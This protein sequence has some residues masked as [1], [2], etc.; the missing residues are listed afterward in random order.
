MNAP[1]P[2]Q[3]RPTSDTLPQFATPD[4]RVRL[5]SMPVFLRHWRRRLKAWVHTAA[6]VASCLMKNFQRTSVSRP[7]ENRV[8]LW[9]SVYLLKAMRRQWVTL[10]S[11]SVSAFSGWVLCRACD[12]LQ[13]NLSVMF[14]V[15]KFYSLELTST[16][17][18][19]L[20]RP[21]DS[22]KKSQPTYQQK[23]TRFRIAATWSMQ[24]MCYGHKS[25]IENA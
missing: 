21:C 23:L 19:I 22:G 2:L 15:W 9:T 4:W 5:V 1:A 16:A 14:Y 11:P 3:P 6:M 10:A 8:A 18:T 24:N 12:S 20:L 7:L 13:H 17:Q 25:C